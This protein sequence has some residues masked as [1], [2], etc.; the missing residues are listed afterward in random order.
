[1]LVYGPDS[2]FMGSDSVE[3]PLVEVWTDYFRKFGF[4]ALRKAMLSL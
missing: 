2:M 3:G 1:M 4:T